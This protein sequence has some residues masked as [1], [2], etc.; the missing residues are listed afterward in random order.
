MDHHHGY[1]IFI[2]G[3]YCIFDLIHIMHRGGYLGFLDLWFYGF[4]K[5]KNSILRKLLFIMFFLD[6]SF[7]RYFTLIWEGKNIY[8][9]TIAFLVYHMY[10]VYNDY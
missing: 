4:L 5:P 7:F 2:T 9:T 1:S 6:K 8:I 10:Y 3:L